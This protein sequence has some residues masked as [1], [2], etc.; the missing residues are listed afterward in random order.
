MKVL[1]FAN[2]VSGAKLA[3][4]ATIGAFGVSAVSAA[5]WYAKDNLQP[6]HDPSMVRFEDGYALMSTNNNL[7]LWTSEDAYTWQNH[8][9]T[10]SKI[11]QWAYTYAPTT[12]G[13]W[14]PD[15]YYMNGEYRVY[16]CVSVFGKRTSAIGY[17]STKS[18]MPGTSGYGW[19]DHGHVFHT[20]ASDKYNAIDAD[21]VRDM[22]GNY[23]MA[24]GSFGLGIQLIKLDAKTGLQANDDKTV[25][26]IARRT[27]KASG[28]AEE[29]PS[30]IEHGG[31][32]FL[33]TA[34]DIC[35]QQGNDIEK[36]TYKTAYGRAD[37]V[38]G[39]YKDRAGYD[40]ANGGGTILMERYG[41]YVGPGG[42]EAFQDLNRVRFVH[43][44]YD[45][46]GDK[47]NHIHIRD[48]VFTD[49]N[50]AEM[51]QPFLG[52]YL[53]AEVEHGALTRAVSGD[54]AIT[55]SNT[56]S[57]GEYLAYINTAGSKIRLPM[58]IMQAG[59]YLL[60]YRYANG[61][62]GDATHKVTVNGK[63]QTVT[64]PPTGSW[65]T[66]PEK[67]IV[68]IPA[69]LKRGGNFIEIEPQPNGFFSE[70]DRIDFLRVIRDTIPANGFDNGI[71]VRLTDK[72]EFAIKDGG[73]AIFENVV[74]DSIKSDEVSIQVKN[75][76][77]GK[78]A[79]RD[80]AKNGI[81]LAECDLSMAKA[82]ANGWSE[83]NCGTL[84][85]KTGIKD[86]YLTAS[87][88]SG[89][90]IVGNILFKSAPLPE[91]SSSSAV[92]ESSSSEIASSSSNGHTTALPIVR[93]S[94]NYSIAKIPNGYRVHF[95][96]AGAHQAYLLNP[97]GQIVSHQKT[98]GTDIEFNNLPKGRF[99]VKVK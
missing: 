79:I 90:A 14:A 78:L 61:G 82:A 56:A 17:Q 54:L 88:V 59:E 60:R 99:I 16:Y 83:A 58:N 13:I 40:M 66:F 12:E 43:H 35:C 93:P 34:W 21:V 7:Q 71:R 98:N 68:M 81:V 33:F 3:T 37:K 46:N 39:P 18:I 38:T 27:S 77:A 36:T 91:S 92:A 67:S 49:D 2:L 47:Y 64:L 42:G 75:A 96:N 53:S 48:V 5:D 9:S 30:L 32:Y 55:R 57:N 62:E 19:T 1:N 84:K 11:P 63:S 69:T 20:V 89:E 74:T 87:G 44:Y 8:K 65:G 10:V 50:W 31:K 51:G 72:D 97:M 94:L 29:G 41:R 24:F 45:L 73:Y 85:S 76:T 86:F 15:I 28:G 6:G 70:L 80:G 23:W 22:Q 4:L 95:D 52:R 26:N 25:Y